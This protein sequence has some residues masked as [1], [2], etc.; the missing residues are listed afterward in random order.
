MQKNRFLK[1]ALTWINITKSIV[2]LYSRG[3]SREINLL[4]YPNLM[5]P[6]KQWRQAKRKIN[7]LSTICIILSLCDAKMKTRIFWINTGIRSNFYNYKI[8]SWGK[9]MI[10]WR[11]IKSITLAELKNLSKKKTNK[12]KNLKIMFRYFRWS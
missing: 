11:E 2:S 5:M 7:W 1:F 8:R 6:K 10:S 4:K 9:K 12:K 3:L